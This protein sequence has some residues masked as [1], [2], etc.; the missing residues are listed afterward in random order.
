MQRDLR[1]Y[2]GQMLLDKGA[3]LP[4]EVVPRVFDIPITELDKDELIATIY[5]LDRTIKHERSREKSIYSG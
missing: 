4:G 2:R 1:A 3:P 5:L